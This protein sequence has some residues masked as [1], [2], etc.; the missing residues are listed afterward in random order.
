MD[1][2]K[3]RKNRLTPAIVRT[4]ATVRVNSTLGSNVLNGPISGVGGRPVAERWFPTDG[5]AKPCRSS[6]RTWPG[7]IRCGRAIKL[8]LRRS[9]FDTPISP[10]RFQSVG[11]MRRVLL[12]GIH[13]PARSPRAQ[14]T[15]HR[16]LRLSSARRET[17]WPLRRTQPSH[18]AQASLPQNRP[19][20]S[21]GSP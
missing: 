15:T 18:P 13:R 1:S 8:R 4:S 7:H 6:R 9:R 17:H 16:S 21:R 20:G 2:A 12:R 19:S 11:N 10:L 3:L 14:G 5:R